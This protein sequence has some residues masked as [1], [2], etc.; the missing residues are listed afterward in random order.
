MLQKLAIAAIIISSQFALATTCVVNEE[1]QPSSGVYD[2]KLATVT[3]DLKEQGTM[4]LNRGD[5]Y[6]SAGHSEYGYSISIITY[7][8]GMLKSNV[9]SQTINK[10]LPLTLIDGKAKLI[11]YCY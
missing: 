3:E 4:L 11:V 5:L 9:L 6:V 8:A 1:S 10:Q 7:V 2:K